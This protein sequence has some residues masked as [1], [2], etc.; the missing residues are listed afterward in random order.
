MKLFFSDLSGVSAKNIIFA[1][2]VFFM[3]VNMFFPASGICEGTEEAGVVE[4]ATGTDKGEVEPDSTDPCADSEKNERVPTGAIASI[5]TFG[6]MAGIDVDL[7]DEAP[8]GKSSVIS[9]SIR[10]TGTSSC[11]SVV[12]NSSKCN[13]YSLGLRISESGTRGTKNITSDTFTIKAG[14]KREFN[15]SCTPGRNY[16]VSITSS[17]ILKRN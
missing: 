12:E 13:A 14:G 8:G 1:F 15:F 2:A 4:T 7:G 9:A 11:R 5:G 3:T 16:Q 17:K 10:K 6:L